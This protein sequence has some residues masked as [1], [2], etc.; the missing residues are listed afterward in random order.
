MEKSP[1]TTAYEL[2]APVSRREP[3]KSLLR[4]LP[5][6]LFPLLIIVTF[7]KQPIAGLLP[8]QQHHDASLKS[9]CKQVDPLFP[10]K[11]DGRLGL[12]FSYLSTPEFR[13]KSIV[14]LSE[15]VQIPTES[16]DDLGPIGEDPRWETLY[17][18]QKFLKD[19]FPR[20]HEHM[21]PEVVNTHGLIYTWTGSDKDLKP[22]LLL[23]HQDVVPVPNATVDAWTH[24]PY[25][26]YYDGKFIWGRGSSDCK[27][28]LIAIMESMEL[29]I[30][31]GFKPKRTIVLSFGFDEEVSGPQGAGHLAPFLFERYGKDGIAALVD[32]GNSFTEN[33]GSVFAAPGTGEK[34][35]TDVHITIRM[36]G[37]HSS[38][39]SDHTS[40]GVLSE[41][42]TKIEA[43]QYPTFL[44][45]D[46]P[47]LG[48][49]QCGAAHA[50]DFPK[51]IKKLLGNH[52]PHSRRAKPD[53]LAIEAAKES[54]GIKYLMQT[55]QA[56]DVIEGG[57]K[58]NA[59]P[60]RVTAV[61]NHRINNGDEPEMIWQR[62]TALAKPIAKK[63][64][65]TLH[66]FDGVKEEAQS[67]SLW[68]SSTTMRAAPTTPTDVE[69]TTPY[70]VLAGTTRALYGTDIIVSPG[71]MTGTILMGET[72]PCP[73]HLLTLLPFYL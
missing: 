68:N 59:L 64:N 45:D 53:Y 26:G 1:Q 33:W 32:E 22:L 36:P 42:I 52:E 10:S 49:L 11:L 46:N 73:K 37:G 6:F 70:S 3:R 65:L 69:K 16:Y 40:I 13:S 35:A 23:S 50:A 8:G 25:S 43:K 17:D 27:N 71:T 63:Y 20:M 30:D 41:L 72:L 38:I 39:P 7:F 28:Q 31:A 44:T 19:T 5:F 34:G 62:I 55:S 29:F 66:S 2:P 15:A 57:V 24:P 12:M 61:V 58:V 9:Q 18:F 54:R 67:I 48:Q 47:Y 4:Y 14:R 21:Q 60:E 56:V 51:K